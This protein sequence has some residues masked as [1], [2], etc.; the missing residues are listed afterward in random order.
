MIRL[1][2]KRRISLLAGICLVLLLSGGCGRGEQAAD[3][4]TEESGQSEDMG[5]VEAGQSRTENIGE[6][7]KE[8]NQMEADDWE[9]EYGYYKLAGRTEQEFVDYFL[10]EGAYEQEPCFSYVNPEGELQMALWNDFESGLWCG[11]RYAG[12][13]SDTYSG[14]SYGFVFDEVEEKE[15]GELLFEPEEEKLPIGDEYM[16]IENIKKNTEYDDLGRLLSYEVTGDYIGYDFETGEDRVWE[17]RLLYSVNY[18]YYEN[19]MR[20]RR[21]RHDTG[22]FG[23]AGWC[24]CIVYDEKDREIYYQFFFSSALSVEYYYLYEEDSDIPYGCLIID[25]GTQGIPA[26]MWMVTGSLIP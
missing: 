14:Y 10:G 12:M 1:K 18:T 21:F 3:R 20:E 24:N 5:S 26:R 25:E 22:H 9:G 11:I 7:Q 6:N 2:R 16:G 4:D 17:A 8:E 15:T 13:H 23:T 19:G